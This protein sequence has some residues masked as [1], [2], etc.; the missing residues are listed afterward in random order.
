M[1]F[2]F[3]TA[4]ILNISRSSNSV[5]SSLKF[6]DRAKNTF[7]VSS[8]TTV[9]LK[10]GYETEM[11]DA[12]FYVRNLFDKEIVIDEFDY[13]TFIPEQNQ[14]N[15]AQGAKHKIFAGELSDPRVFGLEFN[16]RWD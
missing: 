1:F 9:N 14:P 5:F 3:K 10:L 6:F 4:L 16:Y 2:A 13:N 15:L 11:W 7:E 12:Y 8:K